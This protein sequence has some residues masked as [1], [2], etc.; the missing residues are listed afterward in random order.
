MPST[1]QLPP[2]GVVP[3]R[4]D[5]FPTLRGASPAGQPASTR[6]YYMRRNLAVI[7]LANDVTGMDW[8]RRAGDQRVAAHTEDGEIVAILPPGMPSWG[9]PA[10]VDPHGALA[11]R[12]GLT[13]SD[14]PALFIMDRY[15]RVFAGNRGAHAIPDLAPAG[16]PKWLEFIAC[17]CT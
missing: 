9:V 11:A 15:G 5:L 2:A 14:L 8:L 12:L 7:L 17:R 16:I 1:V 10:I 3:G 13:A 4:G 6:D